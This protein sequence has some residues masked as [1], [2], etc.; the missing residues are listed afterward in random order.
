MISLETSQEDSQAHWFIILLISIIVGLGSGVLGTGLA[1]L[2]HSIQHL[3]YGYSVDQGM[4]KEHFYAGVSASSA[5]RRV[6]ILFLCGLIAGLG[7]YAL[8]TKGKSLVSISEAIRSDKKMP[9]L[10]T[11][12]HV[13]LQIITVALGSPLGREV[14]PRELA[15]LFATWVSTVT[16]LNPKDT[17]IMIACAAGAGLAAVYNVPFGGSVFTLE[18]LLCTYN[19]SAVIPAIITSALSTLVSWA[20]LG[21]QPMYEVPALSLSA[22]LVLWAAVTSPIFGFAAYWFTK[23]ATQQRDQALHDQRMIVANLINFSCLGSLAIYFPA[24]LGNGKSL[25]DMELTNLTGISLSALLLLLHSVIVW[26]SLRVGAQGGLLTPSLAN[27]ALLAGVLG[28][29][30]SYIW[31]TTS[32][33]GCIL[34]GAAAFL[35]AAQ[36]MPL[37]AMILVLEFTRIPFDFLVPMMIA[38]AGSTITIKW[39]NHSLC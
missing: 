21:N 4:G 37:T 3:A 28:G 14:A 8:Y 5:E 35:A 16:Q 7:W 33:A 39:C 31:P 9:Y 23:V 32:F 6:G 15:C 36:K 22:S 24:L 29:L 12:S 10:S 2:L 11:I 17:K 38:V 20:G 18:V 26:S 19:W 34:I 27:G 25:M 30:W 1:L 13:F